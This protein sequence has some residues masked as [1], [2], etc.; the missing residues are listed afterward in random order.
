MSQSNKAFN[1]RE[2]DLSAITKHNEAKLKKK[3]NVEKELQDAIATLKKP[4]R[5][6]AVKPVADETDA[7]HSVLN[8]KQALFFSHCLIIALTS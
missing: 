6:M 4:N 1:Q 7:R 2:V 8:S 3:V 5:G